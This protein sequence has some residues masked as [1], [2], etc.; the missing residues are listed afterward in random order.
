[1]GKKNEEGKRRVQVRRRER[2]EREGRCR[3]CTK[4]ETRSGGEARSERE[5]RT[6]EMEK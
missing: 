3:K 4:K 2:E 6:T 1:M 5:G